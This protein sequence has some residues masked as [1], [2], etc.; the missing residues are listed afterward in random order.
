MKFN[1][2]AELKDELYPK[3]KIKQ[4]RC[5]VR[6]LCFNVDN[7]VAIIKIDGK[8]NFGAKDYYELPGGGIEADE[9]PIRALKR[10]MAE[11]LGVKIKN[12]HQLGMITYDFNILGLKT[13]AY[14]FSCQVSGKTKNRWTKIEKAQISKIKWLKLK[15]LETTLIKHPTKMIGSIIHERELIALKAYQKHGSKK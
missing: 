10:E 1:L 6:A 2:L 8:D 13:I 5:A 14:Y 4:V 7:E 3:K 15:E 9:T 11:E 12:I